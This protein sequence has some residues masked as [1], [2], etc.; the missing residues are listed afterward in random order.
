MNNINFLKK[1]LMSESKH[2]YWIVAKRNEYNTIARKGRDKDS[3]I[4]C[5]IPNNIPREVKDKEILLSQ[6][7]DLRN[8]EMQN[9]FINEP[10]APF[11]TGQTFYNI[12]EGFPIKTDVK[13]FMMQALALRSDSI[14]DYE[15]LAGKCAGKV[16]M[17]TEN[18]RKDFMK[19]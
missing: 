7:E 2:E 12:Y 3:I 4:L 8:A 6:L 1:V 19:F 5:V 14:Y 11:Q 15:D 18:I 10:Y 17:G 9:I 16:Q 13:K